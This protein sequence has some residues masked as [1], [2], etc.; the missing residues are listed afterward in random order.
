MRKTLT[1]SEQRE[2]LRELI[3]DFGTAMLVTR[4][5]DGGLRSRPLAIADDEETGALSFAT[6]ID[7]P[8][9][10][11]LEADPHVNVAMQGKQKFVSVTG[12]ARVE[13]DRALIER[14]WS[15]AWKPWFPGGKDDPSLCIL[16]VEPTEAAYWD[17]SGGEGVR[18]LFEMAKAFVTGT[19]AKDAGRDDQQH[20]ARM[21]L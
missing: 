7:S 14:L 2:H 11:E 20:V 13:R 6:A 8:K 15:E 21:K 10:R 4:T 9:M 17:A 3:S 19:R 16:T 5:P 18:Y 12:V 1:D